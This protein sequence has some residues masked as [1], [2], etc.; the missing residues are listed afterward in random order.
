[1][2][3]EKTTVQHRK[4][5]VKA[6]MTAEDV[7][8]SK[9]ATALQ[10]KYA[11]VFDSDGPKGYSQKKTDL[12][13]A[14][15]FS[16][17]ADG[18]VMF[19]TRQK[20]GT[21][22]STKMTGDVKDMH[23]V[24]KK[25]VKSNRSHIK[26]NN[27]WQG[28]TIKE[29]YKKG[30]QTLS[31]FNKADIDGDGTI[32]LNELNR[33]EGPVYTLE[34]YEDSGK[35]NGTFEGETSGVGVAIGM[36]GVSA[37]ATSGKTKGTVSGKIQ[38]KDKQEFY[39]GVKIEDVK[40]WARDA[41]QIFD[42][43]PRDGVL[44]KNEVKRIKLLQESKNGKIKELE[45]LKH[46]IFMNKGEASASGL[47]IGGMGLTACAIGLLAASTGAL[48]V[49]AGVCIAVGICHRGFHKDSK[50]KQERVKQLEQELKQIEQE[51]KPLEQEL[52]KLEK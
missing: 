2:S 5:V 20:D 30:G 36:N 47:I 13:N 38:T 29:A 43:A 8:N 11:N 52:K 22:K 7:K 44:S 1:M 35:I 48:I 21:K 24:I 28:M 42:V 23:Y 16:E 49:G 10:K 15:T 12:F 37:V 41:F 4:L 17:K 45:Q 50:Q 19:W 25:E 26:D 3:I 40:P 14:T 46:D 6:G 32:S 39:S 27:I 31:A 33:Y 9:D 51:L 34:R 18:S